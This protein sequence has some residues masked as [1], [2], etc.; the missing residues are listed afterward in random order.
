MLGRC[1]FFAIRGR[2]NLHLQRPRI[3]KDKQ[4]VADASHLPPAASRFTSSRLNG[5]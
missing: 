5:S 2:A 1:A 4:P 3:A